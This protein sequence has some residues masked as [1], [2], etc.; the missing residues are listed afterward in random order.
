[1]IHLQGVDPDLSTQLSNDPSGGKSVQTLKPSSGG[2]TSLLGLKYLAS[3]I[4]LQK[5]VEVARRQRSTIAQ[6]P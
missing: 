5:A 2:G 3:D 4:T 6:A 1:M